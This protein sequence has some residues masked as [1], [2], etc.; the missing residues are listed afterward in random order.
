METPP[1][2]IPILE[3]PEPLLNLMLWCERWCVAGCCGSDAFDFSTDWLTGW[4]REGGE[5]QGKIALEKLTILLQ[6]IELYSDP[7][8]IEIAW[9]SG[10]I[11]SGAGS[12]EILK[13]LHIQLSQA[14][15]LMKFPPPL[16]STETLP[17]TR[18]K[19]SPWWQFWRH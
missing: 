14:L 9:W 17:A 19:E 6:K 13:Y 1:T 5:E 4:L 2:N 10:W 18:R 7:A 11:D 16:P 15:E 3:F 12:V 8:E